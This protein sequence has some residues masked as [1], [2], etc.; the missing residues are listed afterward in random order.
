MATQKQ[1]TQMQARIFRNTNFPQLG[2]WNQKLASKQDN[3]NQTTH[4]GAQKR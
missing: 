3:W 1:K 2:K 4:F